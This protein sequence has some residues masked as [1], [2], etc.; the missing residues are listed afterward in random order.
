MKFLVRTVVGFSTSRAGSTTGTGTGAASA[1]AGTG[2][3]G[4]VTGLGS[5][6]LLC[7]I[8]ELPAAIKAKTVIVETIQ[9]HFSVSCFAKLLLQEERPVRERSGYRRDELSYTRQ[10][11]WNHGF[12]SQRLKR[13][14]Q[15]SGGNGQPAPSE[16]T[17]QLFSPREP[18]GNGA[19]GTAKLV[20]G[21]L[22]GQTLQVAQNDRFPI[23]RRKVMNRFI[24]H[25]THSIA[26]RILDRCG[27]DHFGNNRQTEPGLRTELSRDPQGHAIEP[28]TKPVGFPK[29]C[30]L[31]RISTRK[32][33]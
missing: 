8:R 10:Q 15:T 32:V 2:I 25:A 21:F 20:S 28:G 23:L 14:Q 9:R 18:Y 30:G 4:E 29:G 6:A 22:V 11:G 27:I 7:T 16:P 33:A 13:G 1:G 3:V 31:A 24:D 19:D 17:A 5:S 12:K 26:V